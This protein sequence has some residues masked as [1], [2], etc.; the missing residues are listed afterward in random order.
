ML[1]FDC[2]SQVESGSTLSLG[3]T[4]FDVWPDPRCGDNFSR[5]D[6]VKIIDG[7]GTI[8]MNSSCGQMQDPEKGDFQLIPRVLYSR[9]NAVEIIFTTDMMSDDSKPKGWSLNWTTV[10]PGWY[11]AVLSLYRAVLVGTWWTPRVGVSTR[12]S[13]S[14][15][16]SSS[17]SS[18]SLLSSSQCMTKL[19]DVPHCAVK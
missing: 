5:F 17:S 19:T 8:L 16:L 1:L 10:T 11:L 6:N 15:L 4:F 7:D 18:S 2:L 3:F 14:P 13:S 12:P 9:T